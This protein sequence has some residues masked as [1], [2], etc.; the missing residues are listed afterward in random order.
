[1]LG[2]CF[3]IL[4]AIII[5]ISY[6]I[7]LD[8]FRKSSDRLEQVDCSNLQSSVGS[9][10]HRSSRSN[11]FNSS[12]NSEKVATGTQ[13]SSF[14]MNQCDSF[15]PKTGLTF[16]R[17]SMRLRLN[18]PIRNLTQQQPVV[19]QQFQLRNMGSKASF[20]GCSRSRVNA[21]SESLISSSAPTN[22]EDHHSLISLASG[23]VIGPQRGSLSLVTS[24]TKPIDDQSTTTQPTIEAKRLAFK[25]VLSQ[26]FALK[27]HSLNLESRSSSIETAGGSVS[28]LK[29]HWMRKK[30]A[31]HFEG[32]I[33]HKEKDSDSPN[34]SSSSASTFKRH[35]LHNRFHIRKGDFDT[36]SDD[37]LSNSSRQT[38]NV[39]QN[40]SLIE[41][42]SINNNNINNNELH[43]VVNSNRWSFA[44]FQRS[45]F[46]LST[47]STTNN[48]LVNSNNNSSNSTIINNPTLTSRQ[49]PNA[50]NLQK[51]LSR[52]EMQ[53][54]LAKM[55]FY[56]ILLWIISWAPIGVLSLSNSLDSKC[57]RYSNIEIFW[58]STMPKLGP[59]FDVFI[60]GV[61][62]PKIKVRFIRILKTLLFVAPRACR[63]IFRLIRDWLNK[64]RDGLSP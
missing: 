17:D 45:R 36:Q 57:K 37:C 4:P 6:I 12:K 21:L 30:T 39:N 27:D 11:K 32:S 19:Q 61:S 59:T 56:L 1:M 15:N 58:A 24:E 14:M 47:S 60:Y 20:S 34:V 26:N 9:G 42:K 16:L 28:K 63:K 50:S 5:S 25:R 62:H 3:F 48:T 23:P 46:V 53:L 43:L 10:G 13:S 51:T 49:G 41:T 8:A 22:G 44:R 52:T 55:S 31:N 54:R 7:I 18:K 64:R 33:G 29:F 2:L 35:Q 40:H 38:K